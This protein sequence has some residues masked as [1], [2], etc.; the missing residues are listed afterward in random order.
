MSD[1]A[2]HC[3]ET[4]EKLGQ[5]FKEVHEWLDAFF[6]QMGP[7]HRKMR[8]HREGIEEVRALWGD[9]AAQAAELH[10][11]ADLSGHVP[12]KADYENGNVDN[13]GFP[14]RAEFTVVDRRHRPT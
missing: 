3:K 11:K 9:A 4:L 14:R 6:P 8:H 10:I 1:L 13:Q 2:T 5:D 12:K 7:S